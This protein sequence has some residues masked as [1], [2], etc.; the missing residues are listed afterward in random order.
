MTLVNGSSILAAADCG[1]LG[2]IL[3]LSLSK[4]RSCCILLVKGLAT[5]RTLFYD[6]C[7]YN[8]LRHIFYCS[9][10]IVSNHY[11]MNIHTFQIPSFNLLMLVLALLLSQTL[12]VSSCMVM[13]V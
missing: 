5:Y 12:K 2:F 6:L 3:I 4:S 8:F 9:R 7:L 13:R 1:M 11:I 10:R